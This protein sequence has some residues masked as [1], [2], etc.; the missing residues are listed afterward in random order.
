MY[1]LFNNLESTYKND[2]HMPLKDI[3]RKSS[4]TRGSIFEF[5]GQSCRQAPML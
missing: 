3:L 4:K 2:Q 5:G 1:I